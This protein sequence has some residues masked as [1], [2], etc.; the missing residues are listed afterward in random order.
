MAAIEEHT[1]SGHISKRNENL[2]PHK[3]IYTQML[4]AALSIIAKKK[5]SGNRLSVYQLVNL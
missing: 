1:Y 3:K 5:K 4:I 2:Q